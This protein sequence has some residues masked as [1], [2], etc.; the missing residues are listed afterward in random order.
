MYL[1]IYNKSLSLS[2]NNIKCKHLLKVSNL[3]IK[4]IYILKEKYIIFKHL[5]I[6]L[7]KVHDPIANVENDASKL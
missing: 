1:Y 2:Y 7:K 3:L 4:M 5:P 6:S